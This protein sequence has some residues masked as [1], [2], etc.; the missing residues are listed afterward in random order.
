MQDLPA[1]DMDWGEA[2]PPKGKRKKEKQASMSQ[3]FA[4]AFEDRKEEGLKCL[5]V[6]DVGP[7]NPNPLPEPPKDSLQLAPTP[8]SLNQQSLN[9]LAAAEPSEL[10][11]IAGARA[12]AEPFLVALA[13]WGTVLAASREAGVTR[14]RVY[15]LADASPTFRAAM[16]TAQQEFAELLE[17]VALQRAMNGSERLLEFMLRGALPSKYRDTAGQTV[18]VA[19]GSP[20]VVD[21]ITPNAEGGSDLSDV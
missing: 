15:E 17:H 9:Q 12:W 4:E 3:Q 10:S 18:N 14:Q 2:E 11:A 20:I 5:S 8:P 19:V 1:E 21:V 13:R 7:Q 6:L 16:A